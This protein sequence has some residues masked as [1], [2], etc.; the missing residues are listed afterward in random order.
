[1]SRTGRLYTGRSPAERDADRKGRLLEAAHDLFGSDGYAATSIDRMC[2][3]A[4]VSTRHYY[5]LFANKEECF[6]ALYDQITSPCLGRAVEVLD[7]T[8][9]RPMRERVP[10]AFLAYL[11]PI[12]ADRKAT[13]IAFVES[14]VVGASSEE[15][16]LAFRE[17]LIATVEQEGALAVARGEI[18]ERNFRLAALALI[19]AAGT[20]A[21]D[22]ARNPDAYADREVEQALVDIAVKLLVD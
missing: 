18:S 5:L 14:I 15:H 8:A 9:G 11:Q 21:Y 13:R 17:A 7:R 12:L 10:E 20:V 3:K 16:R 6:L 1:M 22:W 4:G 2:T 19:G